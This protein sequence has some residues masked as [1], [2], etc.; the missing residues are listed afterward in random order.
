MKHF[1][2]LVLLI[3]IFSQCTIT[4]RVHR[5]GWHVQQPTSWKQQAISESYKLDREIEAESK[6]S[7]RTL[8]SSSSKSSNLVDEPI[9]LVELEIQ[10]KTLNDALENEAQRGAQFKKKSI[11]KNIKKNFTSSN[12]TNNPEN[13]PAKRKESFLIFILVIS[14]LVMAGGV[15]LSIIWMLAYTSLI[16]GAMAGGLAME[17]LAGVL[18]SIPII[19]A[20]YGLFYLLFSLF[21]KNDPFYPSKKE[22]HSAFW[23]ISSVFLGVLIALILLFIF[24]VLGNIF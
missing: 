9:I 4:K 21:Y 15:V 13:I 12:N 11:F 1:S 19:A 14:L 20:Y 18:V 6:E 7:E 5:K 16:Y 23:K 17:I 3:L 8:T 10:Q 22:L 24:V 2:F